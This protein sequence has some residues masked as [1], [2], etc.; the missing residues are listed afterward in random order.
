MPSFPDRFWLYHSTKS[1]KFIIFSNN[2]YN[3]AVIVYHVFKLFFFCLSKKAFIY[4]TL[5]YE[6][7]K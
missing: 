4:H 2:S 7:L 1:Y 3:L 5:I 6:I